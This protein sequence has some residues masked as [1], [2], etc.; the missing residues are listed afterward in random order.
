MKVL[1]TGDEGFIGMHLKKYL[2]KRKYTIKGFDIKSGD[3]FKRKDGLSYLERQDI[4]EYERVLQSMAEFKPDIVIHLAALAGVRDSIKGYSDYYSTNVTG[5][6]NVIKAS[7]ETNVKSVLVASSSSIYGNNSKQPITE[8]AEY[9]PLS[10][11]GISKVGTE[12]VARMFGKE[13]PINIFRPFTVYGT[14]PRKDQVMYRLI[15]AGKNK[16]VFTQYGDGSSSRGYTNI[17]DLIEGIEKLMY[18]KP[19]DCGV[20]NLGGQEEVRLYRLIALAKVRFPNLIVKEIKA[21]DVDPQKNIA[22]IQKVTN[23]VGWFPKREFD[24]EFNKICD[25][26]L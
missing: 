22:N 1:I 26:L 19:R 18:Y 17:N 15:M 9:N 8:D 23:A 6:H 20:F 24:L 10:P 3:S 13:I 7:I 4:R 12:L 14:N 25:S 11:Y 5:T 2:L 21:K 16:T